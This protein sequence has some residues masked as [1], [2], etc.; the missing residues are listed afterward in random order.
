MISRSRLFLL[1]SLCATNSVCDQ[2]STL[3]AH[4]PLTWW[5]YTWEWWHLLDARRM[6]APV[7]LFQ[8]STSAADDRRPTND[9]FASDKPNS[10]ASPNRFPMM[11][12]G[13][14][15]QDSIQQRDNP[16]RM[17]T[18]YC[19][20]RGKFQSRCPGVQLPLDCVQAENIDFGKLLAQ[21]PKR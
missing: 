8:C 12:F 4:I 19:W 2:S 14:P 17:Y 15:I 6:S 21:T 1:L 10:T 13:R 11:Q 16:L 5:R 3:T 7:P 18:M 9:S 20:R